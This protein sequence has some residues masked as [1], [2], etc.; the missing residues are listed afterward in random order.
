MNKPITVELREVWIRLKGTLVCYDQ[1]SNLHL[2]DVSEFTKNV[3]GIYIE[4][5]EKI[6]NAIIRGDSITNILL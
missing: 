6:K 4:S 1:Y 2:M 5:P 3:E